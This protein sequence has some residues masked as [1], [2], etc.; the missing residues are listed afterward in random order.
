MEIKLAD[1]GFATVL[2][3][4]GNINYY[5]GTPLYMAPEIINHK[6]YDFKADIWAVG[7]S[8]F[9]SLFGYHP[10]KPNSLRDLS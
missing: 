10:F 5:C 3:E 1:F 8:L 2:D 4:G 9:V 7:I 6:K